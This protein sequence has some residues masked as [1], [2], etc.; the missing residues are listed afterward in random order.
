M[1]TQ[2]VAIGIEYDGSAFHGWQV[3]KNG[4]S[5]QQS[6]A[7]AVSVVADGP[8]DI[9]GAGRTDA[10]VHAVAQVAH[11]DTEAERSR[12]SWVLGINSNLPRGINVCWAQPVPGDFHARFSATARSYRYLVLN[13]PVRTALADKRCYL[14]REPLDEQRMQE[15]AL[16]LVGE[17]DFSAFRA[18]SC[19]SRTANRNVHRISVRRNGPYVAV[20]ITANAFLHNMV[21][22]VVGVLVRVGVGNAA[23]SWPLE[24]LEG[25]DRRRSAMTVP[26]QGLYLTAVDYPDVF[27]LPEPPAAPLCGWP[28]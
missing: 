18:A 11:F 6:L 12:R 5:I 22:I 21:R 8:S 20:D 19:Q 15:A 13:R 26:P 7:D 17:H 23:V 27:G 16:H 4:A 24:L 14:V 25:R 10:G 1:S 3:Q 2:R 28:A 9:T